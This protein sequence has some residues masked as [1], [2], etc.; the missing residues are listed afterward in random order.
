MPNYSFPPARGCGLEVS[1]IRITPIIYSDDVLL[2]IDFKSIKGKN[3]TK[4]ITGESKIGARKSLFN[5]LTSQEKSAVVL[6]Q[7]GDDIK[8]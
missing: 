7:G 1:D 5:K 3:Y 8:W 4:S 2:E 6:Y